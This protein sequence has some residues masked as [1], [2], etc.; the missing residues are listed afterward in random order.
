MGCAHPARERSQKETLAMGYIR[1]KD[2]RNRVLSSA[3]DV[4]ESI[5]E[6]LKCRVNA[7]FG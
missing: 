4:A 7:T 1:R 6:A 3:I 2:A 5:R